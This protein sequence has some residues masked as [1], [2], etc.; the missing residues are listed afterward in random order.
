MPVTF[1]LRSVTS[2]VTGADYDT[3]VFGYAALRIF[4]TNDV[5]ERGAAMAVRA[6]SGY[7]N[8]AGRGDDLARL[9]DE[10][11]RLHA[12]FC[13]GLSDPKR[14]L[15]ITSL[16]SG[17]KSVSQLTHEIGASQ[18]NVSQHLGLMRDLGLVVGRRVDNNVYYRLSDPRIADAVDLL[19]EIQFDQQNRV[20]TS[21]T[22]TIPDASTQDYVISPEFGG[23]P[24]QP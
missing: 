20:C 11:Y 5:L 21:L 1:R 10:M 14:L 6:R 13:R 12:R 3:S 18:S 9:R 22:S 7:L 19:R 23:Q 15:I 17:E 16:R 2:L 24:C 4:Q 8:A